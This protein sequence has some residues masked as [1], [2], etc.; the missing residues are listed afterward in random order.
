MKLAH[1]Q[2]LASEV[3]RRLEAGWEIAGTGGS[4]RRK[5]AE[6]KDIEIIIVPDRDKPGGLDRPLAQLAA[7]GKID[8]V[9]KGEK[10]M[11]FWLMRKDGG[12]IIKVDLFIVT[13]PAT[14]GVI[15][16]LRTGSAAFSKWLV[17]CRKKQGFKFVKGALY[18]HEEHIPTITE[19]SVFDT[20]QL[21]YLEPEKR[22]RPFK[23]HKLKKK[24][25]E[26]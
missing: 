6:V 5:K 24:W 14:F 20:L 8:F 17:N 13:P 25:E 7:H 1:A 12:Q 9:K 4:L 16:V 18:R 21:E 3:I 23:F 19:L 15:Y 2:T 10:Y 11:Q 22:D 26:E